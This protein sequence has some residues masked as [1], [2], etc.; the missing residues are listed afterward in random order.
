[1]SLMVQTWP[2]Q[3]SSSVRNSHEDRLSGE[4]GDVMDITIISGDL[5]TPGSIIE[6][7]YAE[8]PL[9]RG[10]VYQV[11]PKTRKCLPELQRFEITAVHPDGTRDLKIVETQ[12]IFTIEA[13]NVVNPC[14][15]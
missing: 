4:G 11:D 2:V 13:T 10:P 15:Y 6:I 9:G 12:K 7:P 1:M 8:G 3:M 5:D 14:R